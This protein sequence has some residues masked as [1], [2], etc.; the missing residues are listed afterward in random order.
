MECSYTKAT[1]GCGEGRVCVCGGV[2][3]R[4][5]SSTQPPLIRLSSHVLR[6]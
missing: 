5:D 3:G 6:S 4:M 2:K 1:P